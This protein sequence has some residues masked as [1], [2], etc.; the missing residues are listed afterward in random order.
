M[1]W[2]FGN[3]NQI[4]LFWSNCFVH[5]DWVKH[6]HQWGDNF[7]SDTSQFRCQWNVFATSFV[8][9]LLTFFSSRVCNPKREEQKPHYSVNALHGPE[10]QAYAMNRYK[11][12]PRLFQKTHWIFM[13]T[14]L[15]QLSAQIVAQRMKINMSIFKLVTTALNK[16][17]I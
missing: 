9:H 13:H 17:L 10:S 15:L 7:T 4:S 14:P 8:T 16:C 2:L 3:A 12:L 11:Q 1:H 6:S 5:Y